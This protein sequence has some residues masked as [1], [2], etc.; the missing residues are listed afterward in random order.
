MLDTT[1]PLT[2]GTIADLLGQPAWRVRKAVDAL[3]PDV[4]RCGQYRAV[5]RALLGAIQ[6]KLTRPKRKDKR[7]SKPAG[8]A[9]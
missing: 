2:I 8:A 4:P 1:S 5:P 7:R 3:M 6:D 9:L